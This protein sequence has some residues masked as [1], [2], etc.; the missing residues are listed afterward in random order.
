[1]TTPGSSW[2]PA[3]GERMEADEQ[4]LGWV[5]REMRT[6]GLDAL[7]CRLPHNVLM[8][9]GYAPVLGN[10]FALF[11]LDGEPA[12]VVPESEVELAEQGWVTDVRGYTSSTLLRLGT[13]AEAVEPMLAQLARD[14]GLMGRVVGYEHEYGTVPA[15]YTQFAVTSP[16]TVQLFQESFGDA[17]WRA[18]DRELEELTAVLTEREVGMVRLVNLVAAQGMLAAREAIRTGVRECDVAGAV[19]SAVLA[20]GHRLEPVRR[21]MP[22]PHVL[23]GPRTER[24]YEPYSTTSGR[25]ILRG[26]QL[27]VQLEVY[28][29]GFWAETTR[30]FLVGEPSAEQRAAYEACLDAMERVRQVERAGMQAAGVDI[31]ARTVLTRRG[32]GDAFRHGL[33]HGVGFQAISRDRIP[34]LHPV[35][36]DVLRA[37]MVHNVEPAIYMAG[38]GIRINDDV[39]VTE[40]PP[41][42]LTP[43]EK[44][45]DWAICGRRKRTVFRGKAAA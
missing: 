7:L 5:R 14:R 3:R 13:L 31:A 40:G 6:A 18:A 17:E 10:S 27:L 20:A 34:R 28:L 37:G 19:G 35:S 21:V 22:F 23:S 9:T 26:D 12:L 15:S 24:G 4:R 44:E 32:Y 36:P 38:F 25:R 45:L 29:D 1:V 11:P 39:L 43:L 42:Q 41:E 2:G 16:A 30:T 33:G 8:L